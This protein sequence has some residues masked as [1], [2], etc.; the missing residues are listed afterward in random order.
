MYHRH[1]HQELLFRFLLSYDYGY[2]EEKDPAPH[3]LPTTLEAIWSK[4][5]EEVCN[6]FHVKCFT[7]ESNTGTAGAC[8]E[9]VDFD[10]TRM[11]T[12]GVHRSLRE[13][14]LAYCEDCLTGT[15]VVPIGV[16]WHVYFRS[17]LTKSMHSRSLQEYTCCVLWGRGMSA[18]LGLC[19]SSI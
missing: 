16:W 12:A 2:W 13:Y 14:T 18:R 19:M 6:V 17:M 9:E 3:P 1:C 15:L 8:R 11:W 4:L 10:K 5:R 7:S